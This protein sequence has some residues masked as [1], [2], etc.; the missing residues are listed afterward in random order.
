[1]ISQILQSISSL[2]KK[3]KIIFV[4]FLI[5]LFFIVPLF[6]TI[7]SSQENIDEAP[8][9]EGS[10]QL[11]YSIAVNLVNGRDL[12]FKLGGFVPLD[13]LREDLHFFAKEH[14]PEYKNFPDK[15]VGFKVDTK[16]ITQDGSEIKF[17]GKYGSVSNLISVSVTKLKNNQIKTSITDTKDNHNI[18]AKL[19]S[20]NK[21]DQLIGELPYITSE[22]SL[23]YSTKDEKIII[24]LNSLTFKEKAIDYVTQKLGKELINNTNVEIFYS[25]PTGTGVY[26]KKQIPLED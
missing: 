24:K 10:T 14:Y 7:L 21:K 8:K 19:P 1:M 26:E 12:M 11:D 2:N 3:N 25:K 9:E 4:L 16:K 13:K 17:T 22:F 5:I 6:F 18:D 20:N 15:V 23:S